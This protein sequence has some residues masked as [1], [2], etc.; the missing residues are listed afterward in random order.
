MTHS[1]ADWDRLLELL[2]PL[3]AQAAATARRLCRSTADGDDLLQEAVV[4]AAER[5]HS[6]RDDARF[7][8]WFYAVLLNVHRSRARRAFWRRFLPLET[9]AEVIGHDGGAYAEEHRRATRAA[10][11]LA[12]LSPEMREAVVLFELDGFSIEEIASMQGV[13]LSAVKTRLVRARERLRRHYT[14][15]G[16]A[17]TRDAAAIEAEFASAGGSST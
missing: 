7:R 14:R 4:R 12:T 15:L 9:G 1:S 2:A 6:L 8:P 3:H 13:T 17:P 16:L 10:R 5:L 11:A